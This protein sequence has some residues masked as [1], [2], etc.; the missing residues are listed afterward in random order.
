MSYIL[1]VAIKL[2]YASVKAYPTTY[3]KGGG[4]TT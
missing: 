1:F 2:A 4:V 3:F